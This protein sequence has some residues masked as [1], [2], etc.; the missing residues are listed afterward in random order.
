MSQW[1][2]PENVEDLLPNQAKQLEIYRRQLLDLYFENGYQLVIPSLL[3]YADSL[4][5]FGKD[6]DLETFKVF[7]QL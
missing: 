7:D 1:L 5:A 2:L 4:N 6:L 3:E